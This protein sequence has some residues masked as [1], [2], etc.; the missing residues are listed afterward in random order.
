[1]TMEASDTGLTVHTAHADSKASWSAYVAWAETKSVFVIL[2]QPRIYVPIPKRAFT[3]EQL[4]EFRELLGRHIKACGI[5]EKQKPKG[6]NSA[7]RSGFE[8]LE[9]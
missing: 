1:M 2:P 5:T 4:V 6:E 3:P 9:T 7:S 8:N